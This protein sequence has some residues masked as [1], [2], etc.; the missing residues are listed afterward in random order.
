M[1]VA[2]HHQDATLLGI[3][4]RAASPRELLLAP[5]DKTKSILRHGYNI[6]VAI[7]F[8]G[9]ILIVHGDVDLGKSWRAVLNH[10]A[11][12]RGLVCANVDTGIW[13]LHRKSFLAN[14]ID[15]LGK[16]SQI[17]EIRELLE[18]FG[19]LTVIQSDHLSPPR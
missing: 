16:S 1:Q 6:H 17:V 2:I 9:K 10:G 7:G 15:W 5:W 8:A 4:V 13:E 3:C 12:G 14:K 19:V 18:K 11:K